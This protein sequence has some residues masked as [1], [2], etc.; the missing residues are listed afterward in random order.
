MYQPQLVLERVKAYILSVPA[1]MT[2]ELQ[3]RPLR[4]RGMVEVRSLMIG[5]PDNRVTAGVAHRECL[6]STLDEE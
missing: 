4:E 3:H 5:G 1:H 2:F 6:S